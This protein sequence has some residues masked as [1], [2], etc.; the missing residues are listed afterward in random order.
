MGRSYVAPFL[1]FL[2]A[3]Q[4]CCA[5]SR[6]NFRTS[7]LHGLS[8]IAYEALMMLRI[9]ECHNLKPVIIVAVYF[10]GMSD[11]VHMLMCAFLCYQ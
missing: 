9:V 8:S 6:W 1:Q 11:I 7:P 5:N 10:G 3:N 2:N 4:H